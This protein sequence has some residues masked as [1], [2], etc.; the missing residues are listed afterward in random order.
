VSIPFS[1]QAFLM[2]F[3]S[4]NQAIFPLQLVAYLLGGAAAAAAF[5]GSPKAKLLVPAI[6]GLMWLWMGVAYHLTF[7]TRI[8][9]AAI[10]FG[11]AYLV[12]GG[13]FLLA[14]RAPLHFAFDGTL[15]SVSGLVFVLYAM[16]IYPLLNLQLGHSY[17]Q[18]PVFGVAPCPTTIFSLGLLLW[19][20]SRV[21]WWLL[22]IPL[23]WSLIG[24]S[25]ALQLGMVEDSG[26]ALAALLSAPLLLRHNRRL[27]NAQGG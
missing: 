8:N 22:P 17:P 2:L 15:R 1:E 16:V 3:A 20:R 23:L 26:L 7:F 19:V 11:I 27:A 4:Y 18:M 5:R 10:L 6:L 24:A 25:A 13:L 9:P 21:P 12:Q 14:L